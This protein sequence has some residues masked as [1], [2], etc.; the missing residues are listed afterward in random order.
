[1]D[2]NHFFSFP[3]EA[4]GLIAFRRSF[5]M[6]ASNVLIGTFFSSFFRP[7]SIGVSL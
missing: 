7:S 1:M 5:L 4:V 3:L 2:T 6:E